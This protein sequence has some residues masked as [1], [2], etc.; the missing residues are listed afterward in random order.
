MKDSNRLHYQRLLLLSHKRASP[1]HSV[2][3]CF[4]SSTKKNNY[5]KVQTYLYCG[6]AFFIAARGGLTD[7]V[8]C[9]KTNNMTRPVL[10]SFNS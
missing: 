6:F 8:F 5:L 4:W 7:V 10:F 2:C 1:I 3:F 9:L